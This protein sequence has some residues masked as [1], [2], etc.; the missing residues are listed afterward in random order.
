MLRL[1]SIFLLTCLAVAPVSAEWVDIPADRDATLIESTDGS[2]ANGSGPSMFA[3]HTN[4]ELFGVRRALVRFDVASEL[5]ADAIID[6]VYLTLYENRLNLD[7]V[8]VSIHRV[9]SDWGE[10][11]SFSNG[12][13]GA[14]SQPDDTTWLHTF[15]DY[16]YWSHQ[17]GNFAPKASATTTVGGNDFFTW[18]STKQMAKNVRHWRN[19]PSRNF[20]WLIMG[21]EY[22][23]GSVKSF[24]SRTAGN[25]SQQPVLTIEYHLP[26]E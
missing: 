26:G 22:T 13:S 4:Q 9:L 7:P 11:A 20:G 18:Q 12:G 17:G 8:E 16:D 2:S 24:A 19:N 15:Y 10:G 1:L 14:L 3:G 5:H 6:S 21:D 25:I 23:R